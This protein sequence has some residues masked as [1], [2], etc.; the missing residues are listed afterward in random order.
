MSLDGKT[1]SNADAAAAI[2]VVERRGRELRSSGRSAFGVTG[3]EHAPGFR[4]AMRASGV[5]MYP[6][7]AVGTLFIVDQFQAVAFGTL[8]PE[9]SRTLGLSIGAIAALSNLRSLAVNVAALPTA[10][11]VQRV[12]RRAAVAVITAFLWAVVTLTTGFVAGALALA[13]VLVADGLSSGSVGA[14]HAPLLFDIYPPETRARVMSGYTAFSYAA[15]ILSPAFVSLLAFLHLTWRGTF[16]VMGVTCLL[17][18]VFAIR[19]RDP[20]FGVWDMSRLRQE[21]HHS[22]AQ[23]PAASGD[24]ETT[25]GFFENIRRLFLIPTVR[26]LLI[27]ST[28]LGM[29]LG[30]LV[31]FL[32]FYLNDQWHLG[33]A[34]RGIFNSVAF[35]P[36]IPALL[37][38]GRRAEGWFR[39]DP[40][41]LMRRTGVLFAAG[42]ILI[43]ISVL[44]P[45]LWLVTLL[46]ALG[47]AT[48]SV[49]VPAVTVA[50]QSIMPP[51]VRPHAAALGGIATYGVGAFLGLTFLTS[52]DAR[53]G[54]GGAIFALTFPGLVSVAILY[55]A[56][57][58]INADL[59]RMVDEAIEA[60]EIR[61]LVDGGTKL[62]LLSCRGID[63]AYDQLQVLFD[64]SFT[65]EEGEMVA[66]L[67]TNGA[68][69]STLLKVISG[70][71]LPS[72]G[73]VRLNGADITYLDPTRRVR[74][75]IMQ[76]AGGQ[77]TYLPLTVTDNLKAFGFSL[78]RDKKAVQR[79][80]DRTFEVFPRLAERRNQPAATMSGGEN[81][82]LA[83]AR[84]FMLKPRLLLIDELS[85][86]LAPKIVGELLEMVRAI[87]A[88]GTAVVLVEQSVNIALSLVHHAYFME[89]GEIKFDGEAQDLL[90]RDDLLRS[91]FLAGAASGI[92]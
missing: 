1:K 61:T 67:G 25:L 91:V 22:A 8:S 72:A 19:L 82:M 42:M 36:T 44:M 89:K 43:G 20:G 21:V 14:V 88:E 58:T 23:G 86:G 2:E 66:L 71:G 56:H 15:L 18:A 90:R 37:L 9:I 92:S 59:D 7:F 27:S 55:S 16:L 75:G 3:D 53:L 50:L 17:A 65:V 70:L 34:G 76:I 63:F 62:P 73:S 69:K 51:Q 78:G 81:Q 4:Q 64:V 5:G 49:A 45:S 60:E 28:V 80:I 85:L 47:E 6:L 46:F 38:F 54:H 26:R 13:L 11:L 12:P 30:P 84:A 24:A 40:A 31:V 10:G 79:G 35:I 77:G 32:A 68:G 52:L 48:I 33:A 87:N 39:Q 83:L 74:L 57:R 29:M 41:Q